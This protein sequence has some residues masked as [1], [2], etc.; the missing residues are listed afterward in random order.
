MR[1]KRFHPP[2]LRPLAVFLWSW[3]GGWAGPGDREGH[4]LWH[5]LLSAIRQDH[6]VQTAP[7]WEMGFKPGSGQRGT[8]RAL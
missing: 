5:Q 7:W 2:P 8:E 6:L 4:A 3:D 1:K